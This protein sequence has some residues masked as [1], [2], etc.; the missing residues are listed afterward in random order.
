MGHAFRVRLPHVVH[1][2]HVVERAQDAA[3]DDGL[4]ARQRGARHG[5]QRLIKQAIG[6]GP[7]TRKHLKVSKWRHASCPGG[8]SGA[9]VTAHAT[10]PTDGMPSCPHASPKSCARR[11]SAIWFSP[12]SITAAL[13][14]T[15]AMNIA[16]C[17]LNTDELVGKF[18]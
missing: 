3:E 5:C 11:S 18:Q 7:I 2:M 15:L 6:P 9:M 12:K 14:G 8:R 10:C 1:A 13:C 16:K 4:F 17:P